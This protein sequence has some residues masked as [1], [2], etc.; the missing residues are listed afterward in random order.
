MDKQTSKV[1]IEELRKQIEYYLS[2]RNL[3]QDEFFHSAIEKSAS[4]SS[5]SS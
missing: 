1:D 2:D 4:V 5:T 3:K